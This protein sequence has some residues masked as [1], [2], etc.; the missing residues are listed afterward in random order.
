M[1]RVS[2]FSLCIDSM[3]HSI[4]KKFFINSDPTETFQKL[5]DLRIIMSAFI[6][7]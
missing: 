5:S 2:M 6:S 7:V 1:K 4:Y 3:I